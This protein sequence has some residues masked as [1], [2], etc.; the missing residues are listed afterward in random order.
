MVRANPLHSAIE[1][2]HA[3]RT[4][5]PFFLSDL[6][7]VHFGLRSDEENS[8]VCATYEVILGFKNSS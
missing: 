1:R 7:V 8:G 5:E 4:M 2:A 3:R 6:E